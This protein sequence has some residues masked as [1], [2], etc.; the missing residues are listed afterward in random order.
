[1]SHKFLNTLHVLAITTFL[2][3]C[4]N[5]PNS[6]AASEKN[7]ELYLNHHDS[8]KYVGINTCKIC[9]QGIY[10]TFI[11]T[12]MGQSF[13]SA[14]LHK[15][16]A[17]FENNTLMDDSLQLRYTA[18]FFKNKLYIT[19]FRLNANETTFKRVEKVDYIIGSGQHTNSHIHN[20]NGYLTQMPMTF[21]TQK[22]K[23][24]FP[25]GFEHGYNT[26]FSRK[27]G[28]ECMSCHNA[29]PQFVQGSENK[30]SSVPHG[31]DCERCHGPGSIH[32]AQKTKGELVDTANQID[33]SIV[34][35]AKLPIDL[36]F[37]ICQRCHLQGNAILKPGKSFFD[38]KPGMPLN[39]VLS[40]FLPKYTNAD[41]DFI[42]ASHA[43]RLKQS[44]CF[45]KSASKSVTGKLK[46]YRQALTCLTC[47]NPHL[48]V[49][50]TNKNSF[51][52]ACLN[53]HITSSLTVDSLKTKHRGIQT[54][55]F[56]NCV[57]CH[58]PSSGSTDIPHVSVHDH[59]IRKPL[60]K[61]EKNNIK[62]FL[63]L[64]AINEKKP[65]K[66]TRAAAYINQFE[67]FDNKPFYL[68]SAEKLLSGQ[69]SEQALAL[70]IQ[71]YFI[72]QNFQK[73]IQTY[74]AESIKFNQSRL[75]SKPGL[76]NQDAWTC[77]RLAESYTYVNDLK[78]AFPW[79]Q[80][81]VTL[82][83]YNLEFRNKHATLLF[84]QNQI[85]EA[86][87]E[88]G[89]LI[90]ENPDFLPAYTNL[91][92]VKMQQNKMPEAFT[93]LSKGLTLDPDNESLLLN[94]ATYH[95]KQNNKAMA[96]HFLKSVLQFHPENIKAKRVL[97]Q[98][99]NNG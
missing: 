4:S 79:I 18:A 55:K 94:L 52:Q 5:T 40:V 14:G 72:K 81:A 75:F 28:L 6:P 56:N 35:P 27:I 2:L 58:M 21:Y 16:K 44:A 84:T 95:L 71:L 59:Y 80:K 85:K 32:V 48:S 20:T 57:T 74:A 73:V 11:K 93:L 3:S 65:D 33:Y 10:E 83:P 76:S 37:D 19:E 15:S 62:K 31:I 38:F 92:F 98:L 91:A 54:E 41:K 67:K 50:E 39:E 70:K 49:K 12:G 30:F 9:H 8:A 46:P 13:D 24:D 25:P 42:M 99:S 78:K 82:A 36:Q 96:I 63:G 45:I 51:N 60:S 64:F 97:I 26:R 23:W 66:L 53:C 87:N 43:D 77:Y 47:H 22:K 69:L 68:D 7:T 29:Y 89:S 1:M 34:N 90:Q 88:W 17:V 86:E 61:E